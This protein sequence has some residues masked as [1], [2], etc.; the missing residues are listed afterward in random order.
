MQKVASIAADHL[1]L[2]RDVGEILFKLLTILIQLA[3]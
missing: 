2:Q 3:D 1:D